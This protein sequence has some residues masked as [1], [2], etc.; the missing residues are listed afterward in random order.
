MVS[1]NWHL[2][3][4][5]ET[6]CFY[7]LYCPLPS[8]LPKYMSCFSLCFI[9]PFSFERKLPSL[10]ILFHI[11]EMWDSSAYC[12]THWSLEHTILFW[13]LLNVYLFCFFKW[14]HR[15][16]ELWVSNSVRYLIYEVHRRLSVLCLDE[17]ENSILNWEAYG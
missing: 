5:S 8:L 11:L 1:S 10:K 6:H 9:I 7:L 12:I 15:G 16:R 4:F 17:S 2:F 3:P 13:N 14:A